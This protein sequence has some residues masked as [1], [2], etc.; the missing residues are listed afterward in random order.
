MATICSGLFGLMT[1]ALS[2][3]ALSALALCV[4]HGASSHEVEL[5]GA[6]E[7]VNDLVLDS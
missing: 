5:V 7:A 3:R 6:E 2:D 4:T 1:M